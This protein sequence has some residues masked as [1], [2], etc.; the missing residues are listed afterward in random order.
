MK[1]FLYFDKPVLDKY[2]DKDG[3]FDSKNNYFF[4]DFDPKLEL[5]CTGFLKRVVG[6]NPVLV[7][8]ETD[9]EFFSYDRLGFFV[10][11][12][13]Y[14]AE[15]K[16]PLEAIPE[17]EK[18]LSHYFD[19][20]CETDYFNKKISQFYFKLVFN[21]FEL[22]A[23]EKISEE[24]FDSI[25]L[26]K[27]PFSVEVL[28]SHSQKNWNKEFLLE[29]LNIYGT[30]GLDY[31]DY[32]R[33]FFTVTSSNSFDLERKE[34]LSH[35]LKR[36]DY[37]TVILFLQHLK[38]KKCNDFIHEWIKKNYTKL[39][40]TPTNDSES[41]ELSELLKWCKLSVSGYVL[42]VS[43]EP[44]EMFFKTKG[45]LTTYLI[46]KDYTDFENATKFVDELI[47]NKKWF[48]YSKH[49]GDDEAEDD[50]NL[51]YSINQK[52]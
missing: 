37:K 4:V 6:D 35:F 27:K 31:D 19:V 21:A 25:G 12:F 46:R 9:S 18:M 17:M 39:S 7:I 10:N 38:N 2:L 32:K 42:K 33:I 44:K 34:I 40:E 50:L 16:N 52:R 24:L 23:S 8:A 51:F 20:K 29:M 45:E 13:R 49:W 5:Y 3:N 14:I 11:R 47:K 1:I 28:W 15:Y 30:E 41:Q 36:K 26:V 22:V 43:G 48:D